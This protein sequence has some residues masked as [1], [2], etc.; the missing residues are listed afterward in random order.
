M[1]ITFL[2][3]AGYSH[4]LGLP[5]TSGLVQRARENLADDRR[6]L[7]QPHRRDL[8]SRLVKWSEK[9]KQDD[10]EVLLRL[11]DERDLSHANRFP[12][13]PSQNGKNIRWTI[14]ELFAIEH[15]RC[16]AR[17]DW[18]ERFDAYLGFLYLL[19]QTGSEDAT[20]PVVTLN[21][22]TGTEIVVRSSRMSRLTV[23]NQF[24]ENLAF[25]YGWGGTVYRLGA[26]NSTSEVRRVP[27]YKV[28]GSTNWNLCEQ[29]GIQE[30]LDPWK[31]NSRDT[32]EA[33]QQK[34]EAMLVY[35][36][37]NKPPIA[38]LEAIRRKANA[39]L[40]DS[41]TI[42]SIGVSFNPAD[43]DL[44]D[45]MQELLADGKRLVIVDPQADLIT[46]RFNGDV[47]P[48]S[49]SGKGTTFKELFAGERT[50]ARDK[51]EEAIKHSITV[52]ELFQHERTS[53]PIFSFPV[54]L[55]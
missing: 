47:V 52:F 22:D 48:I 31:L 41:R 4:L 15:L 5:L 20:A 26:A 13:E 40:K 45:Q 33:C 19:D 34:T 29:H 3:G 32:C 11:A 2:L 49:C 8:L 23:L 18:H 7:V 36:E 55:E 35:P 37:R 16:L 10:I 24:S 43:E 42:V 6:N 38:P 9:H 17:P 39:A 53:S 14:R 28:H 30:I 27:F 46:H 25:D 12:L 54:S 50:E 1:S 51:F 44:R 21:W